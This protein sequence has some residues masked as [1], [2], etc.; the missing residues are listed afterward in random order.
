MI[1]ADKQADGSFLALRM[2]DIFSMVFIP[3]EAA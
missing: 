1:F 2:T 3:I